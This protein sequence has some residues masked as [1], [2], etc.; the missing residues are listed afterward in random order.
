MEH[1]IDNVFY[2]PVH[3]HAVFRNDFGM[4]KIHRFGDFRRFVA[5]VC[6]RTVGDFGGTELSPLRY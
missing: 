2:S 4:K 5:G 1:K 3:I 6:C